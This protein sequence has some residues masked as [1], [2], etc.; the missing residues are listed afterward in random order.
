MKVVKMVLEQLARFHASSYHLR[1]A[2]PEGE[3]AFQKDFEVFM[4]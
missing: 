1:Q 4:S 2:Y 3:D